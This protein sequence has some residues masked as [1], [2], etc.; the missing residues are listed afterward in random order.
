MMNRKLEK[1]V[2]YMKPE[3]KAQVEEAAWRYRMSTSRLI[4]SLI[5][6]FLDQEEE[7]EK[8]DG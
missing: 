5:E 8:K 1:I 6:S 3:L 4:R 7:E 2:V